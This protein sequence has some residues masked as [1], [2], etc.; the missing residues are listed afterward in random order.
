MAYFIHSSCNLA[1]VSLTAPNVFFA[2]EL[3]VAKERRTIPRVL[4][5]PRQNLSWLELPKMSFFHF[6]EMKLG[7]GFLSGKVIPFCA[8]SELIVVSVT[9]VSD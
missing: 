5:R 3:T 6:F 7:N 4:P 2:E 8:L 1:G 9:S